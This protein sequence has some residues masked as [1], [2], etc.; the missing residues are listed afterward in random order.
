[1]PTN[2]GIPQHVNATLCRHSS[3]GSSG[4]TEMETPTRSTALGRLRS[5]QFGSSSCRSSSSTTTTTTT[6][7][8][9]VLVGVSGRSGATAEAVVVA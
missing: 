6:T 4:R 8:T 9:R 5:D 7:T 2:G 1:M 3:H